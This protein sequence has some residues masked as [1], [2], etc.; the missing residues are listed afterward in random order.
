MNRI[1]ANPVPFAIAAFVL[2]VLAMS[3][4]YTVAETKQAVVCRPVFSYKACPVKAEYYG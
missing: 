3:S 1:I 4:L 2:T